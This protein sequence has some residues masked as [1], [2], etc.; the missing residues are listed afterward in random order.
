MN[1][2]K[3]WVDGACFPNPGKGGWGWTTMKGE[4]DSGCINPATNNV[5]ELTAPIKAIEALYQPERKLIVISDSQYMVKGITEWIYGWLGSN[6][7]NGTVKNQELWEEL[8][9][10]TSGRWITFKW[11]KGHSGDPGNTEAD[12]L[13]SA[14]IGV[15]SNIYVHQKKETRHP[16]SNFKV[17]SQKG[18]GKHHIVF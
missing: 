8:Y 9:S 13:A 14:A 12:R 4:F 18:M 7:K 1:E 16:L 6:W 2:L 10:I 5:M 15:N 3:V 11:V 17:R